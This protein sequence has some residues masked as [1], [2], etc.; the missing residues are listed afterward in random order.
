[1][2][3]KTG[4]GSSGRMEICKRFTVADWQKLRPRLNDDD[5]QAWSEAAGVFERRMRERFF[6]CIDRLLKT[7]CDSST[8]EPVVPGFCIMGLCCLLVDT[9]QSFYEGGRVKPQVP[10]AEECTYPKG[11]CLKEP[12]TARAFKDFL[13][14]SPHFN[15][16]FHNSRICGDFAE[17]VRNA[18]LHEAETRKGWLIMR[19]VPKDRIVKKNG[20]AYILNRTKFYEALQQDFS[21]YLGQLLDPSNPT[22]RKHFVDKMDSISRTEPGVE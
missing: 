11:R 16:D 18:L 10:A 3:A 20:G 8:S 4:V 12:S 14:K 19:S 9:L 6:R 2:P 22:L 15:K 17:Y 13:K 7:D 1:M 21:D 5:K